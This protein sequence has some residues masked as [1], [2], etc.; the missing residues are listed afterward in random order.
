MSTLDI[1]NLIASIFSII[2]GAVALA[3]AV[4]FYFNAKSAE[5]NA[6]QAMV[7]IKSATSQL[8][9]LSMRLLDRLASALVA[10]RPTEEKLIATLQN[11]TDKSSLSSAEDEDIA[12]ASKPALEQFRVDNLIAA[13]YYAAV[14]NVTTQALMPLEPDDSEIYH[15]YKNGLDQSAADFEILKTWL[16]NTAHYERKINLSPV[17]HLYE[18]LKGAEG[19]IKNTEDFYRK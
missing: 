12:K 9:K 3:L 18:R 11:L 10:P 4:A 7:E 8:S 16:L 13:A 19:H 15:T 5:T 2:T 14:S 1:F 17:K 6:N